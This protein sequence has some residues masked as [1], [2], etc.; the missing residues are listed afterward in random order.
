MLFPYVESKRIVLRPATGADGA[1][2]YDVLFRAG[3]PGLPALDVFLD[4]FERGVQAQFLVYRRDSDDL[5]GHAAL[6]DLAVA[7]HVRAAVFAAADPGEGIAADA[8]ALLVNFA[9]AMWRIRKVYFES[10]LADLA[11]FGFTGDRAAVVRT[12]AVLPEHLWFRGRLWDQY[13]HAVYR[14]H[15]DVDGVELLKEIV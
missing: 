2:V 14:E 12:E 8:A 13:V 7:G 3:A 15:W 11:E 1:E 5:V 10:H 6:S 9:F 4:R